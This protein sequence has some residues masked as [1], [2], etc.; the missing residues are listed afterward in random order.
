MQLFCSGRFGRAASDNTLTNIFVCCCSGQ[1]CFGVVLLS[2]QIGL[3]IY[4]W[5]D[6]GP[7][8]VARGGGACL[9]MFAN[10]VN[11]LI[12]HPMKIPE[13]LQNSVWS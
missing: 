6:D 9:I 13:I 8:S 5:S 12:M 4:P 1:Y 2:L 10:I 7:G 11:S 3:V